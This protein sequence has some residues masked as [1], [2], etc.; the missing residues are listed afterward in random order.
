MVDGVYFEW[1]VWYIRYEM[2]K[3]KYTWGFSVTQEYPILPKH[4]CLE[5]STTVSELAPYTLI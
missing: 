4:T 3:I 2:Q 5:L 1:L